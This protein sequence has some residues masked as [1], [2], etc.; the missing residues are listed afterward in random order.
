MV[1]AAEASISDSRLKAMTD[2]RHPKTPLVPG[3]FRLLV[4]LIV[5]L[6]PASSL[7]QDAPALQ[8]E[9]VN[10]FRFIHDRTYIDELRRVYDGLS[11]DQKTAYGLERALQKL[12]E[13]EVDSRR[14]SASN[15]DHPSEMEKR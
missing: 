7:A 12:S 5:M 3:C 6:P 8:W 10:P 11:A 15:C 9:L 14:A 1:R 2:Q 4:L 13:D